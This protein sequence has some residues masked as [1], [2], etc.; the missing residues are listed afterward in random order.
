MADTD[1]KRRQEAA[2][3]VEAKMRERLLGFT[4]AHVLKVADVLYIASCARE[5]AFDAFEPKQE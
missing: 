4:P 3:V 2:A 1:L 5:V